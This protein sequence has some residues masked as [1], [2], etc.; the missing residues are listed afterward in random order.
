M[1]VKDIVPATTHET[2]YLNK[3]FAV[4]KVDNEIS[5]AD[6]ASTSSSSEEEDGGEMKKIDKPAK[7]T[8]CIDNSNDVVIGPVTQIHGPITIHQALPQISNHV[9]Q[10]NTEEKPPGK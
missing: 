2:K 4:E 8:I 3:V 1:S 7:S 6:C 9:T 10:N 5:N